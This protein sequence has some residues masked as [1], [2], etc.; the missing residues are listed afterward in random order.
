MRST[1][2]PAAPTAVSTV[3]PGSLDGVEQLQEQIRAAGMPLELIQ[4][5]S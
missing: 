4:L 3:R 2:S 5:E 1:I